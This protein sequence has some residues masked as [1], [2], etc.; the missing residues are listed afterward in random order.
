MG[1]TPVTYNSVSTYNPD[2][3][4][5]KLND[6][7]LVPEDASGSMPSDRERR[8]SDGILLQGLASPLCLYS[9]PSLPSGICSSITMAT[10]S[11]KPG[12]VRNLQSGHR[13]ILAMHTRQL[14]DTFSTSLMRVSLGGSRRTR[15]VPISVV[16]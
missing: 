7:E 2:L 3:L 16:T 14:M 5:H 15:S 11:C 10:V 4:L 6:L 8:R 9:R 13:S 1:E 12:F